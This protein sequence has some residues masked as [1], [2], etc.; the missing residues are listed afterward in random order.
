MKTIKIQNLGSIRAVSE[1]VMPSVSDL[2]WLYGKWVDHDRWPNIPDSKEGCHFTFHGLSAEAFPHQPF[3]K[4]LPQGLHRK[5]F[6][7]LPHRQGLNNKSA[8]AFPRKPVRKP[9]RKI[10][11]GKLFMNHLS[12]KV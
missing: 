3:R 11:V 12:D 9:S 8:K 7:E 1:A 10:D 5:A 2:L 4:P 6:Y